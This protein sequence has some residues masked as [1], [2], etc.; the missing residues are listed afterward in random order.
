MHKTFALCLTVC[1]A[2]GCDTTEDIGSSHDAPQAFDSAGTADA[3]VADALVA[4]DA[5]LDAPATADAFSGTPDAS[6]P[7]SAPPP[8]ETSLVFD[9]VDDYVR[10]ADAASLSGFSAITIETWA[11]P[12]I[13]TGER[14]IVGKMYDGSNWE[15]GLF[16]R[17]DGAAE[18]DWSCG[19]SCGYF[20]KSG[21]A[22]FPVDQ[23]THIAG[24]WSPA[25]AVL[26]VNGSLASAG[27][28]GV[29]GL[30]DTLN[31]VF[32]GAGELSG[33]P[34]R[35]WQGGVDEIRVWN[36]VRTQAEIQA[37]MNRTLVG[38]EPGLVA[39]WRMDEGSGGTCGDSTAN[40]NDGRLGTSSGADSADPAWSTDLPF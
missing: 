40:G 19:A 11:K 3:R 18:F 14:A 30:A 15:F 37:D 32:I 5:R 24:T 25:G 8:N 39:Y 28:G 13:A 20:L 2:I 6:P 38:N 27:V 10:V 29:S 35:F 17:S 12:T 1:V 36:V 23:W 7:D 21:T 26:Y 22:A 31:A 9:G 4:P 34:A 16:R 33:A